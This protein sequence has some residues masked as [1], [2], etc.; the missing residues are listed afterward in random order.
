[1]H[2]EPDV[3]TTGGAQTWRSTNGTLVLSSVE[4]GTRTCSS[5][6]DASEPAARA[7]QSGASSSEDGCALTLASWPSPTRPTRGSRRPCNIAG[8]ER[9]RVPNALDAHADMMGNI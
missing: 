8:E 4:S 6:Y 1:M 9:A 3:G 7:F 5:G 2:L